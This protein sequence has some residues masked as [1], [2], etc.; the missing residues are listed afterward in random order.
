MT[1]ARVGLA[2]PYCSPDT[3]PCVSVSP[4]LLRRALPPPALPRAEGRA[5]HPRAGALRN[6][7]RGPRGRAAEAPP[8]PLP[9][10]SCLRRH[11]GQTRRV[12]GESRSGGR[13]ERHSKA[14]AAG[15]AR[16]STTCCR[17]PPPSRRAFPPAGSGGIQAAPVPR[18]RSRLA[19]PSADGGKP[20]TP[21]A[22]TSILCPGSASAARIWSR[23]GEE[24]GRGGGEGSRGGKAGS[25]RQGRLGAA[26]AL[27]PLP[28]FF[29]GPAAHPP[30]PTPLPP[31]PRGAFP[32]RK[33]EKSRERG[34][35]GKGNV[36]GKVGRG[37]KRKYHRAGVQRQRLP[38][39]VGPTP[40]A[41]PAHKPPLAVGVAAPAQPRR[42]R[43][44]APPPLSGAAPAP[45]PSA[46]GP[47][48]ERCAPGWAE[49]RRV[50]ARRE[51]GKGGN[52]LPTGH[53]CR[54]IR[55]C[56]RCTAP[57]EWSYLSL[58]IVLRWRCCKEAAEDWLSRARSWALTLRTGGSLVSFRI[59]AKTCPS[60]KF[61]TL[62]HS[63]ALPLALN[64]ACNH[65]LA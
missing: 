29:S 9:L 38:A 17:Q 41:G 48:R 8:L 26:R 35:V 39:L 58:C 2:L 31:R 33:A 5:P 40:T 28:L 19:A 32:A 11:C 18:G 42:S 20:H 22:V 14:A 1:H 13:R 21:R 59:N 52:Y 16:D 65:K 49:R 25:G 4:G 6:G 63:E 43:G 3:R 55:V 34:K 37:G 50:L 36:R 61:H 57:Y 44:A 27:R 10:S 60:S 23:A 30:P 7:G 15:T 56:P 64:G 12:A 51:R 45:P 47:V 46:R 62:P 54:S 53:S 24:G